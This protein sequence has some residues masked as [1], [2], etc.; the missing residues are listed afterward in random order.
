MATISHAQPRMLSW[1]DRLILWY[2]HLKTPL[3]YLILILWAIICIAPLYFTL[4]FSLKPVA[5][6]YDPPLFW[7]IPF[8][9]ENF[10]DVIGAL[11]LFPRWLLNSL[12][13]SLTVTILRIFFCAMGGY[14]FARMEFPLKGFLFNAMLVSMM[15]PG[16]VTLIPAFLVV[17]PGIIRGGLKLGDITL[18]TGFGLIDNLGGVILPGIV[19]AFGVFMMTQFYKS[20]PREL[21]EAAMIDGLGRWGIFFRI[22]LP[23]SQTQLLT[24]ALLTFQ[25]EWNAFMWPLII[26]R[27]PENFTLPL[28]LNWFRGE[29]Y[30]LISKVLAGS[31]FNTLPILILFFIFQRYFV[32]S[33]AGSGLKEG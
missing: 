15:I 6:A 12:I 31:L 27:T 22:V 16:Q 14:A 17:G 2:D 25:G 11:P 10:R 26:L 23:L 21:E 7:P 28:G 1:S 13:V 29:Y 9:L 33:I 18:P 20:L 30:T 8:T 5:N 19:T 32:Q 24:L 3:F 4:V